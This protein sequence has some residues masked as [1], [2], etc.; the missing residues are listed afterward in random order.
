[1]SVRTSHGGIFDIFNL[2]FKSKIQGG[3][4]MGRPA[5][6]AMGRSRHACVM[7]AYRPQT[8]K[9]T[10]RQTDRQTDRQGEK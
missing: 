5:S 9:Q 3:W 10:N 4:R 7:H 6:N 1:M 2:R 8:N